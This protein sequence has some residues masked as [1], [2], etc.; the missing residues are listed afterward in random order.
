MLPEPPSGAAAAARP[1]A[2]AG[3]PVVPGAPATTD[4]SALLAAL[5]AGLASGDDLAALLLRF[6]EPL[7]HIAGARGGALRLLDE[8]AA[9]LHLVGGVGLPDEVLAAERVVDAGCGVCG[10][11][12]SSHEPQWTDD[13]APCTHRTTGHYF[14]ED[15]RRVLAVPLRYRGRT[16]G[17]VNLF[18]EQGR[19]PAEDVLA[20]C[21][22]VGELLGL[23][24][25]NA[26]LERE[27]LRATVLHERQALAADLHDS[28]GQ[29]LTFVK[30]RLPLLHDA[31]DARDSAGAARLF[32][33]V[34]QAVGQAHGSLRGLL[35]QYRTPPDPLGL[36]HALR[37]AAEQLRRATGVVLDLH[38]A[39]PPHA[40]AA[41]QEVQVAL[42]A[43][44]ALNNIARHAGASRVWLTL[45]MTP[46]SDVQLTV[47][48]DGRG[49]AR[50][51]DDDAGGSRSESHYGLAIMRERAAR[52]GGTLQVA[53]RETGG[54]RVTLRFPPPGAPG[55]S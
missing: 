11:A 38:N 4:A 30:L 16:L 6:L 29:S 27:N 44:E 15:C 51:A 46:A 53:P 50:A 10:A 12:L 40:L 3:A 18:F 24:L 14:G 43:Q 45:G 42:V 1:G 31:I 41:E 17:L 39:L 19:Q 37:Q 21:K 25:H 13:L 8:Q 5:T 22:T 35:T 23:A 2:S 32:E 9:G 7:A 55:G 47:E 33:D 26:Q 54:T 28:I 34:R 20:L 49:L 36:D 52:L 48:D